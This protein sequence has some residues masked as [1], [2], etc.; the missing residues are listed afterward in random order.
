MV[1]SQIARMQ[2]LAELSR[3][4]ADILQSELAITRQ[5]ARVDDLKRAGN[6]GSLSRSLLKNFKFSLE[7][8]YAYRASVLR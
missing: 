3:I 5:Q 1:L 2:D 7:L 4:D 8:Q 6:D